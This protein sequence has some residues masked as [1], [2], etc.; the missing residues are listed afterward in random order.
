M[1]N[2]DEMADARL[3]DPIPVSVIEGAKSYR[4]LR[5]AT[6][7]GWRPLTLDLHVP[8][9]TKA[10]VPVIVYAHGGGFEGGIKEM[11]PWASLPRHGI[12]VASFDYRLRAE[13]VYPEPIDDA[14]AAI[15]WVKNN[16]GVYGLDGDRIGGWGSSAGGY[17]M[18]R[19]ALSDDP[20]ARLSA[21]LLHYPLTSPIPAVAAFFGEAQHLAEVAVSAAVRRATY[22]PPM[23]ISHGDADRR[24]DMQHS[25]H[26]HDAVLAAGGESFLQ[27]V[28][29]ADHVDPVF[30]TASVI[31]PALAFLRAVWS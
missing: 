31:E 17:L 6:L 15:R 24:C 25:K 27:V 22:L 12:A 26:L 14:L 21:L 4:S 13:A 11:G 10:P 3:C 20:S 18:A 29:G 2:S 28:P 8:V 9:T 19:A 1:A 23:H 7:P 30:S 16:A 5:F